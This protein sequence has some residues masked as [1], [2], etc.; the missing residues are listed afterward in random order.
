MKRKTLDLVFS[1]GGAALAALLL[2]L[3][4][5]V[6]NQ[7]N[8]ADDY[9]RDQLSQQQITFTPEEGL[10][11]DE[12]QAECLVEHAGEQLTT[13]KQAECYANEYIGRHLKD[14]NDGKTYSQS[15]SES[16]A[17]A[18]EAAAAME[19]DPESPEAQELD[20]QATAA[21]AKV[22][23]L[24]RGESLR[25]LLLTSYGFSVFGERA[26]QAALVSFL[27]AAVLALASIAGFAHAFSR[28]GQ[29]IIE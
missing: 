14:I 3:G 2:V 4:L 27:A 16:R 29:Q 5:V 12:R 18:E 23:S 10:S 17:L 1:I 21:A 28:S 11:E 6:E 20:G 22:D 24:F 26:A 13:G 8:F 19:A 7:A 9:V 25:G 15:S